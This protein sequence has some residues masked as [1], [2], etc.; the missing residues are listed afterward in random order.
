LT[1]AQWR[2]L[3]GQVAAGVEDWLGRHAGV[4]SVPGQRFAERA[5]SKANLAGSTGTR[6]LLEPVLLVAV[7]AEPD[8]IDDLFPLL[9]QIPF[10]G[11]YGQWDYLGA[12]YAAAHRIYSR[13]GD[14]R[15]ADYPWQMVCFPENGE[16]LASP[17]ASG[18]ASIARRADGACLGLSAHYPR[19]AATTG[20]L[21]HLLGGVREWSVMWALGGSTGWPRARI[22]AELASAV[23]AAH[24]Y[25][26]GQHTER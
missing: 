14:E 1:P 16:Q 21:Q 12:V 8:D 20:A 25:L 22:D 19:P 13:R 11:D 5:V 3:T 18:L 2:E 6:L 15:R 10:T 4:W 7:A 26:A 24:R 23:D 9:A 17:W